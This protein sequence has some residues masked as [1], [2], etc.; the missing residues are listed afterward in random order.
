MNDVLAFSPTPVWLNMAAFPSTRP[1]SMVERKPS[2][3]TEP[4]DESGTTGRLLEKIREGDAE[5]RNALCQRY[6]GPLRRWA[7]GRLPSGARDL[8]DTDDLV[9]ET[10]VSSL[11]HAEDFEYQRK[12]AFESYLRRG[13]LNRIRDELRRVE[14]KPSSAGTASGLADPGPSPLS[15]MLGRAALDSYERALS[16]LDPLDREAILARIE[17]SLSYREIASLL[18]KP[19]PDAARMAVS[20]ALLRLA[21]LMKEP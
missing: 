15:Q 20:R 18:G 10:L 12:G 9:Q 21:D 2:P 11:R 1:G 14:R 4:P 16:S 13:V 17:L 7:R 8:L 19:S 5:A 6:L 3:A